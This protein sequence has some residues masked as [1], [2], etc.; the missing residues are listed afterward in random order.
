MSLLPMLLAAAAAASPKALPPAPL[1]YRAE[2]MT[3]EPKGDRVLLERDVS[4]ERT[5]LHVTGARAQAQF[6]EHREGGQTS[7]SIESFVVDGAV[8]VVR[9]APTA[10][11]TADGDHAVYDGGKQTIV[12]TG[13][14]GPG[15]AGPV[16]REGGERME[17]DRILLHLDSDEVEVLR[18]RLFLQRSLP[19]VAE[20]SAMEKPTPVRIEAGT[21]R[22]DQQRRIAR[23]REKV[24][25]HR[26]DLV[27]RGPRLDARY[28]DKG[29]LTTLQLRGGV[30]MV[31]GERRAV[32]R[33]A[34]YDA[35]TRT[36][37]LT[38]DPRL[39]DR[40]DVLHGDRIELL[41]DTHEVKVERA[42]GRLR[43]DQ[44]KDEKTGGKE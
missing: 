44:H 20:A 2:S 3:L 23:F 22:L 41:L 26:G 35:A 8:H 17:G 19:G 38:G 42:T 40:G 34:D 32:G 16:L 43:P 10:P 1:D 33:Q 27:V 5:D 39:Y 11:R 14:A 30:E 21:L 28:D 18:P 37:V 13:A 36:L 9:P 7:R 29:L 24:V 25:V 6:T 4:L 12:L 15:M 31:E